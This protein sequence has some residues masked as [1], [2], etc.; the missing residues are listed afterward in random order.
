AEVILG[1]IS[2]EQLCEHFCWCPELKDST[3]SAINLVRH[4][5]QVADVAGDIRAFREVLPQQPVG[6][7]MPPLGGSKG[8]RKRTCKGDRLDARHQRLRTRSHR[9]LFAAG[10]SNR[11]NGAV[12]SF[13]SYG[14]LG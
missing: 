11:A 12:G 14:I 3:G 5:I 6:L 13:G 10:L 8:L 1:L 4:R 7:P 2:E 9:S